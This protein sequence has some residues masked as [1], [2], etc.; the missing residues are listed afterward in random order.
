MPCFFRLF[1][2]VTQMAETP[3]G[4]KNTM[5]MCVCVHRG[6]LPSRKSGSPPRT[7]SQTKQTS[8][9]VPIQSSKC[10]RQIA[11]QTE[12]ETYNMMHEH[13]TRTRTTALKLTK[14]Y[15]LIPTRPTPPWQGPRIA[16]DRISSSS[17]R[18][19]VTVLSSPAYPALSRLKRSNWRG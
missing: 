4:D 5:S 14:V 10:K 15:R 2:P 16:E 11:R 13:L 3:C 9:L 8:H 18:P 12:E 1:C 19:C 17:N 6:Y 7:P